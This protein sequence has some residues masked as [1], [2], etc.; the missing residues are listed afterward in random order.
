[1]ESKDCGSEDYTNY[2]SEKCNERSDDWGIDHK[3]RSDPR[4]LDSG[5]CI[6]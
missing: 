5:S 1:M 3:N 2:N 6:V 4:C